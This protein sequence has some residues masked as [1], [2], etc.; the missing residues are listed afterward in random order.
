M[1]LVVMGVSGCG[2]SSA[3]QAIASSLSWAFI[4]GDDL[5]PPENRSKMSAGVPLDDADR[6]P[7]LD[8][9]AMNAGASEC[10]G[11]SVVV[12]CSA[13]KQVYRDRLARAGGDVRFVHLTG[14]PF[15]IAQRMR[16]RRNHFMPSGLLQSQL[17][18]LEP[19]PP[20]ERVCVIDLALSVEEIAARA[21]RWIG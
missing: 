13:L 8:S 12:A 20:G 15:I 6:W 3:G 17:A 10:G 21:V 4:E 18:T 14:D 5:H 7:W 11:R 19:P 9:I 16:A 2:K 1:I